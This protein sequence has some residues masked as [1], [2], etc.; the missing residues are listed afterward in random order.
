[1]KIFNFTIQ[2]NN[3]KSIS[4]IIDKLVSKTVFD[5]LSPPN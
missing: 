5:E 2:Y 1:M 3:L 4:H